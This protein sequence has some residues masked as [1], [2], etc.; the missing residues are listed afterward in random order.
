MLWCNRQCR[1][2]IFRRSYRGCLLQSTKDNKQWCALDIDT[3]ID[4]LC[5][6]PFDNSMAML[7]GSGKELA[8]FSQRYCGMWITSTFSY[9]VFHNTIV[10]VFLFVFIGL[11]WQ[12]KTTTKIPTD[13]H[14]SWYLCCIMHTVHN[15]FTYCLVFGL[16]LCELMA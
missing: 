10:V 6:R 11:F 5:G 3:S 2:P 7:K 14:V 15:R 13:I 1:W 8:T 16:Y 9:I 4:T 12:R